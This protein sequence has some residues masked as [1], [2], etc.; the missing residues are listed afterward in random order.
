MFEGNQNL[1]RA[2]TRL[3]K[4][5]ETKHVGKGGAITPY[6]HRQFDAD[7]KKAV[8][9]IIAD[10]VS[11]GSIDILT[12]GKIEGQINKSIRDPNYQIDQ[13]VLSFIIGKLKFGKTQSQKA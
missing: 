13:K 7:M 2:V 1:V 5:L 6:F 12:A 8:V 9:P 3:K 11:D 10:A 4:A